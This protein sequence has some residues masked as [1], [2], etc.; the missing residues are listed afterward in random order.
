MEGMAQEDDGGKR[1]RGWLRKMM[2]VNDG[3]DGSGFWGMKGRI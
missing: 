1:W 3:G 2:E